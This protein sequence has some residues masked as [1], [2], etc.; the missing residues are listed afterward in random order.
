MHIGRRIIK[1]CIALV[2]GL[3]V[4]LFLILL[5]RA[6]GFN[7][8]PSYYTKVT[9]WA[10]P[11]NYYTP[12]FAGIAVCYAMQN[13]VAQ[14]KSQAKL[15][16]IGSIIGGYF[17]YLVVVVFEFLCSHVFKFEVGS[18][19]YYFLLYSVVIINVIPLMKIVEKTKTGFAGFITCLTY[20]SVTISIR[21]GGLTPLLFTTNRV[22][23][24]VFGVCLALYVNSFPHFKHKNNNV[25]FLCGLDDVLYTDKSRMDKQNLMRIIDISASDMKF[26]YMTSRNSRYVMHSIK[27]SKPKLP[28]IVMNGSAIY[29]PLTDSYS[30]VK[31]INDLDRKH[32]EDTL[33]ELN[34]NAFR[35]VYSENDFTCFYDSLDELGSRE[36]FEENKST[37]L[38]FANAKVLDSLAISMYLVVG[39]KEDIDKLHKSIKSDTLISYLYNYRRLE[40]YSVLRVMSSEAN[41]SNGLETLSKY[42]DFDYVVLAS[43]R[44]YDEDALPKADFSICLDN[45]KGNIKDKSNYVIPTT[46]KRKIIDLMLDIYHQ[47]DYIKYIEKLDKKQQLH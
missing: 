43:G 14:S 1:T 41:K 24:T 28:M 42:I 44:V 6:L 2:I 22:L 21:N 20:L 46:D 3:G 36:Y 33:Q 11:T 31:Y 26:T 30:D 9:P 12:F 39:K 45:A 15:R 25:L 37:R 40:G 23:S 8:V 47:K 19:H 10:V 18:I 13:S 32:M 27:P 38:S 5:N 16:S 34:L 35:F 29:H 7:E 4:Y 17:G